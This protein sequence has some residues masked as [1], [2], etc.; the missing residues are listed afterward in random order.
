MGISQ[1]LVVFVDQLSILTEEDKEFAA[2]INQLIW[3]GVL[4]LTLVIGL[5]C[6][7]ILIY[8]SRARGF[9]VGYLSR[10]LK[11][12]EVASKMIGQETNANQKNLFIA[13]FT[14]QIISL[15]AVFVIFIGFA[16]F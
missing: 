2:F 8:Y 12:M 13:L 4:I 15:I 5:I 7:S 10:A 14:I 1:E 11:Q 6:R 3:V 9:K 16:F